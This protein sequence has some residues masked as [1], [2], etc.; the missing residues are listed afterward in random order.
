MASGNWSNPATWGGA[1]PVAGD[2]V[3]IAGGITVNLNQTANGVA[4]LTIRDGATLVVTVNGSGLH[5]QGDIINSGTLSLWT[6]DSR[7]GT[8]FLHA[9]CYLSGTGSWNFGRI[10]LNDFSLD[11]D[12]DIL[13]SIADNITG[14]PL[15]ALNRTHHRTRTILQFNGT[16]N[17]SIPSDGLRYLYPVIRIAKTA[18]ENCTVSFAAQTSPNSLILPGLDLLRPTD[19][20]SIGT[21]NMLILDGAVSGNGTISGGQDSGLTFVANPQ[22]DTLRMTPG[23]SLYDLRIAGQGEVVLKHSFVI[24][25]RLTVDSRCSLVLPAE[26]TLTLGT[27][28]VN[29]SA[30][31]LECAGELKAGVSSSLTL[32]GNSS[33]TLYL[34]FSQPAVADHSLLNLE[35][36]R[37]PDSGDIR[38]ADESALIVQGSLEI[39][40]GNDFNLAGGTLYLDLTV[41][42]HPGGYFTG[43]DR[44]VLVL[45]GS[46]GNATLRFNPGSDRF[47]RTLRS[48]Y[49]NRSSGRVITLADTLYIRD[50]LTVTSGKLN[51][52]GRLI[53]LSDRDG[54]AALG[55]LTNE[56]DVTGDVTVQV[57]L[58]GGQGMRG[59]RMLAAP[60]NDTGMESGVFSQMQ[61]SVLITGPGGTAN[62]FDA[63]G[64]A[65]PFAPSIQFYTE[66]A[67]EF[68]TSYLLL[69]DI[70]QHASSSDYPGIGKGFFLFFRGNRENAEQKLNAGSNG[71]AAPE[72]VTL[73]FRGPVNKRDIMTPLS[74]TDNAG[75]DYNGYNVV[76]NPY[77]A[78]IDWTKVLRTNV[79]DLV[80]IIRPGGGRITYSNGVVINGSGLPVIQTGQ[81]FYVKAL[82]AG[83]GIRFTESCKA[84]VEAP[85][86]LLN[87]FPG[88][89][90]VSNHES[91]TGQIIIKLSAGSAAEET[92]IVFD[93]GARQGEDNLD[94]VYFPGSIPGISNGPPAG[95]AN[96]I[97]FIPWPADSIIIA[98]NIVSPVVETMR[99]S[100]PADL[101][102]SAYQVWLLDETANKR[103]RI[104]TLKDYVFT[105]NRKFSLLIRRLTMQPVAFLPQPEEEK[106]VLFPVPV[107]DSLHIS[108][109]GASERIMEQ[110]TLAVYTLSGKRVLACKGTGVD[111]SGVMPGTY[112]AEVRRPGRPPVRRKFIKQ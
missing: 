47:Q 45:R 38:L 53:L 19:R 94:A 111:L 59:T 43:S 78:S 37:V 66:S 97:N 3:I 28:G 76:G 41:T 101:A 92:A 91:E 67:G 17:A 112:I 65:Q 8:L 23:T 105:E 14:G 26:A 11:F 87:V 16:E 34:K 48:L 12:E 13:V 88:R 74:Y 90:R 10:A 68:Q 103:M 31:E 98:L 42:I 36:S 55:E 58:T 75:D 56:G 15:S 44:S 106:L 2:E 57:H 25:N 109:S 99:L 80:S 22:S 35:L 84:S 61:E 73:S 33:R 39:A 93:P 79:A 9:D 83:A 6:D 64:N 4:G 86:R 20:L 72:D 50:Q 54:S 29:P 96:A 30:G 5:I 52:N 7:K 81:G 32:R 27:N 85:A 69:P 63:G 21:N 51:S 18:S 95:P 62:G 49:L 107:S 77:P 100:F 110:V 24:R 82:G 40:E 104:D 71:Y 70:G 46:G 108:W 102:G 89:G 1:V 60:I